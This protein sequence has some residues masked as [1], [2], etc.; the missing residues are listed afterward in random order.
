MNWNVYTTING[1]KTVLS[2]EA[3]RADAER[4]ARFLNVYEGIE[5]DYELAE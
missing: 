4:E 5:A 1:Q 3:C 2:V